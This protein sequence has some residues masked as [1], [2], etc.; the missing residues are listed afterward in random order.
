MRAVVFMPVVEL[1]LQLDSSPVERIVL[2]SNSRFANP[3]ISQVL[4]NSRAVEARV[5]VSQSMLKVR[6][7]RQ[8]L[9]DGC[10]VEFVMLAKQGLLEIL[11]DRQ[12]FVGVL[13]ANMTQSSF[14]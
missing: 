10:F 6:R 5:L 4:G 14:V 8:I 1:L 9:A 2:V 12:I 13:V 3:G 7:I 11:L